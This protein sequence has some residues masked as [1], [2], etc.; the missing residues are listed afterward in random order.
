MSSVRHPLP[1]VEVLALESTRTNQ[2]K[3]NTLK[4]FEPLIEQLNGKGL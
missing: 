3:E 4:P 2:L 1:H